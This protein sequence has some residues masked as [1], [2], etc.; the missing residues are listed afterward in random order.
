[1]SFNRVRL[2]LEA[3]ES[4]DVPTSI[5]VQ[6]FALPS[7]TNFPDHLTLGGD[8]NIWFS[9]GLASKVGNIT[10]AGTTTIFD[11][12]AV[13]HHGMDG[14]TR[15]PDNNIWFVELFDNKIG[16]I[17]PSGH[18]TQFQLKGRHGPDSIA[19][20][21]DHNLWVTT[22]DNHVGRI[23]PSGVATF[24]QHKGEFVRKVVSFHGALYVEENDTIGR[25]ATNGVFTGEFKL[26]H[27][28]RLNDLTAGPN[29]ELWFTENGSSGTNYLGSMSPS[30]HI[31]EVPV[32][33]G[34]LGHLTP[35]PGGNLYI[36]QGD[37]L[38]DVQPNGTI[39]AT[40]SLDFGA[41]DGSV[42]QGPGGNVWY[43]EGVLDK[44]GQA[45]VTG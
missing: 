37:N 18:I 17:T 5:S 13:S 30:G 27:P 16:K 34:S 43:A 23:T 33:G 1:M 20:G 32:P 40:Q 45:T 9:N 41:G 35:G 38:L 36:R 19:T 15:G 24:F 8:G 22:F 29:G 2:R 3:L 6:T 26:P 14:L 39:V 7:G 25:I 10:P 21:P 42:V 12:S 11:T 28:G 44:V 31:H 4:R